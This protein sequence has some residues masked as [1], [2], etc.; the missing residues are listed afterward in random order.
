MQF[1]IH[2]DTPTPHIHPRKDTGP[3]ARAMLKLPPTS[4]LMAASEWRTWS[5]YIAQFGEVTGVKTS[6]LQNTV[7]DMDEHLP[8]GM[9]REIGEMYEMWSD[10][11]YEAGTKEVMNT[12]DLE[13]VCPR[14][15]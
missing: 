8:G 10:W 6:F 9:G 11:G 3:F 12:E 13:K 4:T 15:T 1:P 5:S 14:S 2:P 7:Q